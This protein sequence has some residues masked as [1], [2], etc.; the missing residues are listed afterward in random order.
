MITC[1]IHGGG[2]PESRTVEIRYTGI[3]ISPM[4]M[5][6]MIF[7]LNEENKPNKHYLAGLC[8]Q[9]GSNTSAGLQRCVAAS[10]YANRATVGFTVVQYLD[11]DPKSFPTGR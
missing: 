4:A 11:L 6:K 3:G 10:R 2:G 5:P 7:S 9:G 1:S 8:R